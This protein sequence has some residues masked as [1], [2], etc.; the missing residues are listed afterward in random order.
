MILACRDLARFPVFAYLPAEFDA[1]SSPGEVIHTNTK[2]FE[3][4]K[5]SAF[6]RL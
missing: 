4:D 3:I 5:G 6:S 2:N 1:T